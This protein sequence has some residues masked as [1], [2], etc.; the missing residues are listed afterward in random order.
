M[1]ERAPIQGRVAKILSSREL[2][3]NRGTADGVRIGMVFDVLDPEAENIRDPETDEILGSVY[4]PKLPLKVSATEEHLAV[5]RTFRSTRVNVG[6]IGGF[7]ASGAVSKLFQ[8]PEFV[9]HHE[10]FK[11]DDAAWEHI[12]ESQSFVKIGDPVVELIGEGSGAH[13]LKTA[14]SSEEALPITPSTSQPD[15]PLDGDA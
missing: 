13:T 1:P 11:A 5:A 12:D 2:V 4:R 3:I 14:V 7:G 9:E 15:T 10:T 8:P 6:G